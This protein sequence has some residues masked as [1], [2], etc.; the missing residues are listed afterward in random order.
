MLLSDRIS[1]LVVADCMYCLRPPRSINPDPVVATLAS[2][3]RLE[4]HPC[5]DEWKLSPALKSTT[6]FAIVPVD[7]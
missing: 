3:G 6:I 1:A 5:V 4:V 2:V 7:N